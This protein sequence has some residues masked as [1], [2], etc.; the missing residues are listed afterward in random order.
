MG[1]IERETA[2]GNNAMDMGM[3]AELLTPCM[4]HT[5]ETDF[6]TKVSRIASHFEKSFGAGAEQEIV[7]DLLVL[8]NQWR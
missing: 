1:V 5:E 4:Q 3:K 2:S 7:E 6:C 8:Q